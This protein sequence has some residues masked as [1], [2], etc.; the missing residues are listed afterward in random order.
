LQLLDNRDLNYPNTCQDTP[1]PVAVY[2]AGDVTGW[3]DI[4]QNCGGFID[5]LDESFENRLQA[6]FGDGSGCPC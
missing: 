6:V 5:T 2:T 1:F 4:V 3:E